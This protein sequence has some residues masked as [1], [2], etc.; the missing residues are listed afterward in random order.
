MT[1]A[2]VTSS[3]AV[4]DLAHGLLDPCRA[5][6]WCVVTIAP[7]SAEPF[8][9]IVDLDL[10]IGDV[11]PIF[12]LATGPL[13]R[14]LDEL[15]PHR[16]QV[17]GGA[18]RAYPV[19]LA[20]TGRPELSPLRF[21]HASQSQ[22]SATNKLAADAL[23]MATGAGLFGQ[24]PAAAVRVRGTVRS[25]LAGDARAFVQL[26]SGG[27]A[28][29]LHELLF[30]NIPLSW[31]VQEGLP[32]EGFFDPE[33]KR[34][35]LD[36]TDP[37]AAELLRRFPAGSVTLALV[38]AVE[39]QSARI[40]V[41][42]SVPITVCRADVSSNPLDRVDLLLAAGD[43]VRVRIVRDEQGRL[44]L[45][46]SDVDDDEPILPSMM[47]LQG[48][49]PWLEED[50]QL[51]PAP[52][53]GADAAGVGSQ[54]VD[55]FGEVPA[56]S[57]AARAE[58]GSA[59]PG[60]I[61]T[62]LAGFATASLQPADLSPDKLAPAAPATSRRTGF[63]VPGPGRRKVLAPV[64]V[65]EVTPAP[66]P[67]A[68]A[69][70]SASSLRAGAL[71]STQLALTMERATTRQLRAALA[72]LDAPRGGQDNHATLR[73]ELG[74]V[75]AE[76][77]RLKRDLAA[78]RG[79]QQAQRTLLRR[80][81][82]QERAVPGPAARRERFDDADEWLRHEIGLAWID[83]LGPSDRVRWPLPVTFVI[84]VRF[85][86]SVSALDPGLLPKMLRTV[87]DVLTGRARDLPARG[88]HALRR[89]EVATAADLI[90]PRDGARCFRVYVEQNTPSARRLHYWAVTDGTIELSRVVL[91]DDMEP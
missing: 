17:F 81:R 58:L 9:D 49:R 60:P 74:E 8:F 87:V 90:R 4:R 33:T 27:Y 46:L 72:E 71:V 22:S 42:P 73:L 26:D 55:P 69:A 39:L 61:E 80:A 77:S 43:V 65:P 45:R 19:D 57:D 91:H 5:T 66:A 10:Q 48:G 31:V 64:A 54:V 44:R 1:I 34:L 63:P 86:E 3:A 50:R 37:D 78:V 88:L 35:T 20:W 13:T 38:I 11:C 2:R 89:G 82:Q 68:A 18:A 6:P 15:L 47:L 41:H 84:G 56:G 53:G 75:L 40:A 25:L 70:P 36:T 28:T 52:D 67:A 14:E 30:P 79:D 51:L 59:E 21:P 62:V 24:P 29:L 12:V 83:R 7:G 85:A 23:T 32:V 76:N 16:C